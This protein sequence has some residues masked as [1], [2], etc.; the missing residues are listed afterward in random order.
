[1][2]CPECAQRNSV[3]A[4]KCLSCG[5]KFKKRPVPRGA[6]ILAAG[7]GAIVFIWIIASAVVPIF[8]DP[9]QN[10]ARIAKR[11]AQGPSDGNQAEQLMK[12]FDSALK[13]YLAVIGTKPDA[14]LVAKLQKIFPSSAFEIHVVN[15]PRNLRIVE[16]DTVLQ[17]NGYLVMKNNGQAKVFPLTGLEVFDDARLINESAGPMLVLLG[18]SGG[19]PPHRP[20]VKIYGL[21]PDGISDETEK[22]LPMIKGEGTARFAANGRDIV[23]DLSLLSLAQTEKLFARSNQTEDGTIRQSL[24][25]KDAHYVS[26]YEY[27]N[28]PFVALYAV[29][30]CLRYPDLT[31][32]H[33]QYLGAA[34]QELVR[35]FKSSDAGDFQAARLDSAPGRIDYRLAGNVGRFNIAVAHS[36]GNW[37][38]ISSRV[39]QNGQQEKTQP[40]LFVSEAKQAFAQT[41]VVSREP[42]HVTAK[43]ASSKTT[44]IASAETSTPVGGENAQISG[45]SSS[46]NLR[47]EPNVDGKAIDKIPSGTKFTVIG[48]DQGWYKVRYQGKVG[49]V[50]AGLVDY[51]KSDAY[52]SVTVSRTSSVIDDHHKQLTTVSPGER[53]VVLGS[54][55]NNKYRVHLVNGQIGLVDRRAIDGGTSAASAPMESPQPRRLSA[56]GRPAPAPAKT[57]SADTPPPIMP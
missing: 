2:R 11:V 18:H 14:D 10:L 35:N 17:A 54:A 43:L 40:S 25:W 26:R 9:E 3:A 28:S 13:N 56:I 39:S 47:L 57:V 19:Q 38:V 31:S 8:T 22:L 34:G 51:S 16:V 27:G 55:R 12:E 48:R 20:H 49:Y 7:L 50:Y 44:H 52:R 32:A 41:P 5:H 30:R 45:A 15:L 37:Q 1:M 23:L 53:V 29:A 46:I 24:D 36:G 21:L 4:S 33:A 6:K 42:E